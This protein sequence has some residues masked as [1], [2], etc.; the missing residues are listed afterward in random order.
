MADQ[1]GD[2]RARGQG[3]GR[4]DV[5]YLLVAQIERLARRV[6]HRIV[7]PGGEPVF[8]AVFRPGIT[9]SCFGDQEAE[10]RI[11]DHVDPGGRC[12]LARPKVDDVFVPIGAEASQAIVKEEICG[13]GQWW[14]SLRLFQWGGQGGDKTRQ[15]SR[16]LAQPDQLS[17]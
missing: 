6:G 9:R 1:V 8:A 11:G 13:P 3:R 7:V 5:S 15:A 2:W 14:C 12:G 4:P 10:V 17:G 16:L